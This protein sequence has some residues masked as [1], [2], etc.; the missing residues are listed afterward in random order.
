M[1]SMT[2]SSGGLPADTDPTTFRSLLAVPS[3]P[4]MLTGW[5]LGRLPVGMIAVGFALATIHA[6]GSLAACGL[7]EAAFSV[8]CAVLVPL[9]GRLIDRCG[10]VVVLRP[11]A[12]VHAG[13]LTVAMIAAHTGHV[14]VL[15]ATAAVAGASMPPMVAC[16]RAVWPTLLPPSMVTRA[17]ALEAVIFN[18][19]YVVGPAVSAGLAA[20]GRPDYALGAAAGLTLLGIAAFTTA[21][22]VRAMRPAPDS[23]ERRH[24][25]GP[26]RSVSV[27]ALLCSVV[28]FAGSLSSIDLAAVAW[29]RA[30]HVPAA[31]GLLIAAA[32]VVGVFVAALHGRRPA[33]PEPGYGT[34][35]RWLLL[36]AAGTAAA[37]LV[38][39]LP[40]AGSPSAWAAALF[41]IL[42]LV[43]QLAMS[44][45]L[46]HLVM[47]IGQD[48]DPGLRT[49]LHTW[50][51]SGTQVGCALGAFFAGAATGPLSTHATSGGLAAPA[52]CA[53]VAAGLAAAAAGCAL[54]PAYRT[55]RSLATD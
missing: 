27:V 37:A 39:A 43:A 31:G 42:L 13:A 6:G 35:V 28:G 36:L 49:E 1:T 4:M 25:L 29:G 11:V 7:V 14:P 51:S 34:V 21:A 54:V 40:T 38:A 2:R 15:V 50:R 45:L 52:A 47:V 9:L 22:P 46:V 5:T 23:R 24:W 16:Q 3:V 30:L 53:A 26:L 12:I 20:A 32:S 18:V 8:A 55:A 17:A 44:P 48:V 33:S 10:P 19:V 41:A